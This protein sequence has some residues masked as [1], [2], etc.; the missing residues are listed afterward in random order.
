MGP[1]LLCPGSHR[2]ERIR[3]TYG[4]IDV[5]K[6]LVEGIFSRDPYDVIETVGGPLVMGNLEAGDVLIFG[7]HLLHGSLA[8]Q[9]NRF[10][11]SIDTCYQSIEKPV[12]GR[13]VG[14]EPATNYNITN[15]NRTPIE[16]KRKEWGL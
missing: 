14:T 4:Q 7:P 2:H 1:L 9:T 3:E 6:D 8:N 10:R 13:W 15:D 5:D 11:I 16:E 12:D